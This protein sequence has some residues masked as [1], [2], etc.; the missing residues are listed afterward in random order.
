MAFEKPN[1]KVGATGRAP[2]PQTKRTSKLYKHVYI[3]RPVARKRA[4]K[5]TLENRYETVIATTLYYTTLNF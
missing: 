2:S 4:M 1:D 5:S 3:Q